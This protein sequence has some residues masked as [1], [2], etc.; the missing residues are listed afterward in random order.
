M[1]Y[2]SQQEPS[3]S[4]AIDRAK[5]LIAMNPRWQR[6]AI[7]GITVGALA[8]IAVMVMQEARSKENPQKGTAEET[9]RVNPAQEAKPYIAPSPQSPEPR[10]TRQAAG[11]PA[12][13]P[14]E[15]QRMAMLQQEAIRTAQERQKRLQQRLYSNQLVI[16]TPT[17]S[18]GPEITPARQAVNLETS[19]GTLLGGA[20]D[21]NL[22]FAKERQNTGT[23]TVGAVQLQN[24]YGL[25][26]QGT[27]ISGVLETAIK[28]NLPGMVRAIVSEDVY[29]FDKSNLLIPSGS[30]LVGQ[31]RSAV[32]QG[33]SRVFVIWDRLIR[34]DG[35]SVSL[36]SFGT[37]SLGR[38]G[39]E[40]DTDTHFMERFGSSIL[41]SLIDAGVRVGVE[42]AD[43]DTAT[44]ALSTGDNFSHASEIALKNS[45]NIPPT[46]NVDQGERIKV[47]VGRD[48][49]FST[50]KQTAWR[51]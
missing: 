32:R 31:Y 9:F 37:D 14:M 3:L 39:M 45:I 50:V 36:A 16:D 28:S 43:K 35:V 7:G 15:A 20:S 13:D 6:L 30:T 42:A 40:G 34:P 51:D 27:M 23:D 44:V 33:Q 25:I 12:Y 47:F 2:D 38:S 22:Q 19:G 5:P 8:L 46:V 1:E 21:E 26:P 4:P 49:D 48:L 29:S 18:T 24:L 11:E 41:L 17:G 10:P